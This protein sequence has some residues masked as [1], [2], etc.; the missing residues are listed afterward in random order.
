M[1]EFPEMAR[2][3]R[4]PCRERRPLGLANGGAAGGSPGSILH[5]V[6][7]PRYSGVETLV[8]AL[9]PLH[10]DQGCR[11]GFCSL[12]PPEEAFLPEL[13][14]MQGLGG[15]LFVPKGEL[16]GLRRVR[17]VMKAIRDFEPDFILAHT[18]IPAAYARTAAM[19]SGW[20]IR[21]S[22]RHRIAIALQSATNDDYASGA[23]LWP[24]RLLSHFTDSVVT[25]SDAAMEN[26]ARR[27]RRH[28]GL[29][30]ISNSVDLG[31][32]HE[33]AK[34]REKVRIR[35]GLAGKKLALQVGRLS[36][37][38]QQALSLEALVPLLREQPALRLWFAGLTETAE[39]EAELRK[40]IAGYGLSAQVELLGS[41]TDVPELLAASDLYLMPS[42][43]E[44]HSL[45]MIEALASGTPVIASDIATFRYAESLPGVTLAGTSDIQAVRAAARQH[46][47]LGR[48]YERDLSAYDIRTTERLYREHAWGS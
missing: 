7:R 32:F 33:A 17:H 39:Y 8:K 20:R 44:A 24:E 4:L 30:R 2:E 18:V 5:V 48:R 25:V 36:S 41:R 19:L 37:A 9:V 38:K 16:R 40:L 46:L 29:M 34:R 47:S 1:S 23:F 45:A 43:R 12:Q 13:E 11:A 3:P 15:S 6:L 22:T 42:T 27:V 31:R 28:P 10:L 35:L 21:S 26:Y 14:R